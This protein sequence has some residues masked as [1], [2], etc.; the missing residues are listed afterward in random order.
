M[1]KKNKKDKEYNILAFFYFILIFCVVI[2]LFFALFGQSTPVNNAS[3]DFSLFNSDTVG[4]NHI[5]IMDFPDFIVP[6]RRL[7]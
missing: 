4:N 3:S 7:F 2:Y 1:D 5:I 6:K